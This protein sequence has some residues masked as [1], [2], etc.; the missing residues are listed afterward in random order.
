MLALIPAR[1][2]SKGIPRKN[3]APVAGKPL[4][5]WTIE[6]ARAA[7]SVDRVVVS[8]DDAEIAETARSARAEVLERP[9]ELAGDETPMAAVV[10]HAVEALAPEIVVLLQPTSPLRTA[11]HVDEAVSLLDGDGVV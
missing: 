9:V 6:V 3:L 7:A 11:R 8:T 5:V 10:R 2:G 1:G 4:L